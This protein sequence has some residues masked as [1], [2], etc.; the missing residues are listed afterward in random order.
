M[1]FHGITAPQL[2]TIVNPLLREHART[3]PAWVRRALDRHGDRLSGLTRRE[4]TST[5]E[6]P[7]SAAQWRSHHQ[8]TIGHHGSTALSPSASPRVNH[9]A[10][11]T[12]SRSGRSTGSSRTRSSS[13]AA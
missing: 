1:P 9:A 8:C 3:D 7:G 6:V 12:S 4:A 11:T 13:T 2:R 10:S 5:S